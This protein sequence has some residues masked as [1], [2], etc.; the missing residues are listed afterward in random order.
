MKFVKSREVFYKKT[1]IELFL[2]IFIVIAILSI[3]SIPFELWILQAMFFSIA[4]FLYRYFTYINSPLSIELNQN[5]IILIYENKQEKIIDIMN[6]RQILIRRSFIVVIVNSLERSI[7][8]GIEGFSSQD[9]DSLKQAC[10]QFNH[11]G[12]MPA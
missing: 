2:I 4:A 9:V 12:V 3:S 7:N 1:P 5:A 8:I 10:K 6:I 11:A